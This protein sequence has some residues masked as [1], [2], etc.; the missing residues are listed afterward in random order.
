MTNCKVFEAVDRTLRDIT[1]KEDYLF[2]GI[3][4]VLGGDFAQILPVVVH[5]SR[6]DIVG[7]ILQKSP[8]WEKLKMQTLHK[9][10]RLQGTGANA[11]FA[12]WLASISYKPDLI[13]TI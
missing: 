11:E 6:A 4:F 7:A 3:P 8:I 5:G 13:K 1:G 2:G 10:M 9:N 12:A